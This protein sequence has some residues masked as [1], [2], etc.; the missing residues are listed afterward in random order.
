MPKSKQKKVKPTPPKPQVSDEVLD[1]KA[2]AEFL[3]VSKPTFY[4]WLAQGK[5]KG[6]KAGTQWRFYRRDLEQFLQS[7]EPSAL[8][9]DGDA[10][11]KAVDVAVKAKGLPRIDW[12]GPGPLGLEP[13]TEAPEERTVVRAA[14]TIMCD[15]IDA[16]ASDIHIDMERHRAWVRYRV[17]GVLGEVMSLPKEAGHAIVSRFKLMSALDLSER[18]LPQ[19]GRIGIRYQGLDYDFR[20]ATFPAIFGESLVCRILDQSSVLIGM[21]KLGFSRETQE[22]FER[23]VRVPNGFVIV[24]GPAGSG[25]TTTLYSALNLINAPEKKVVTIE[26]PVEYQLR[27]IMQMHVNRKAGLTF[28]I[29]LRYFVR[30]DPDIIFV[31]DLRDQATA[32]MC[33][34]AALTGHLVLT[35]MLPLTAP[36]VITRLLDMGLEPFIVSAALRAALAQR[37]VR[38]VC[39]KCKASYQPTAEVLRRLQKETGVDLSGAKFQRGKGCPECRGTGYRARTALFELLEVDDRM[40]EMIARRA[41]TAELREAAIQSGMTTLL[42]DGLVKAMQGITTVEEVLRV[43][44]L[45]G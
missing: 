7:S 29:A 30:G 35:A 21:D 10:L 32:E 2:A 37:L 8:Q 39:D 9:V 12:S 42:T 18:R 4:R 6:V 23:I 45:K 24:S 15:A 38:K 33:L 14:E 22:A 26:D 28:D 3:K 1:L 36:E 13:E 34:T 27:G 20:T 16:R 17:D 41:P 11:Q 19:N 31:G 43:L 40:R 44:S 5:I 25:R